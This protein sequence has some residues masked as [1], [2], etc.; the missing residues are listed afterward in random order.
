MSGPEIEACHY[1]DTPAPTDDCGDLRFF[2]Y[3]ESRRHL[4]PSC[5]GHA[6][7]GADGK[8]IDWR[9]RGEPKRQARVRRHAAVAPAGRTF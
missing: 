1:C 2:V 8:L 3:D 6:T 5:A 4:K 9:L 7:H